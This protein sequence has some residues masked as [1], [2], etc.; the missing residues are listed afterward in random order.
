MN[1]VWVEAYYYER[2]GRS[3]RPGEADLTQL[4]YYSFAKEQ[5]YGIRRLG[6]MTICRGSRTKQRRVQPC[7]TRCMH[8]SRRQ[9][10]THSD[11]HHSTQLTAIAMS[12]THHG[13]Q[14]IP[15]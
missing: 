10:K 11:H 2:G 5:P 9:G 4:R 14:R 1:V 8:G 15:A 3:I 13:V 6:E 12:H 7:A